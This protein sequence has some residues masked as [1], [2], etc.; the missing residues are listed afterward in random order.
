MP[1]NFKEELL[2]TGM[3]AGMM[4]F[5]MSAYNVIRAQGLSL[6]TTGKVLIGFPLGLL[7]AAIF[8]LAVV[9][10]IVK[11]IVFKYLIKDPENTA[12]IKIAMTISSLMV[13]G[14][15]SIMTLY[16]LLME[17]QVGWAQ[18]GHGWIFN[19]IV[20]LPLQLLIVGPISRK[21][22]AAVQN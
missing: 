22:L 7:V 5:V 18:Y 12:P 10:P 6:A 21:G 3:M 13:L 1:N 20:A 17:G 2:F 19:L 11:A 4:V 16:G 15:V 14:M 8:D 9:G